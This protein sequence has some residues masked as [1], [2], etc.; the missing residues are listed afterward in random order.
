M[1]YT[2]PG[3]CQRVVLL[4]LLNLHAFSKE[5]NFT[6]PLQRCR[7]GIGHLREMLHPVA[8]P[9]NRVDD[10]LPHL[11]DAGNPYGVSFARH[12]DSEVFVYCFN[13]VKMIHRLTV[14]RA[15]DFFQMTIPELE[16]ELDG[17]IKSYPV[18]P[19]ATQPEE[20]EE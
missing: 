6:V 16:S 19:T 15:R 18:I 5:K 14:V 17:Y 7:L 4:V 1:N 2:D 8:L 11:N 10:F 9:A 20:T 3:V 13:W 12:G